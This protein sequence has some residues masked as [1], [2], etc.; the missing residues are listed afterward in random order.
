MAFPRDEV[1]HFHMT[2]R[3]F[4]MRQDMAFPRDVVNQMASVK[5]ATTYLANVA[6]RN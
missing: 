3:G 6:T 4:S 5:I 2:K 1:W